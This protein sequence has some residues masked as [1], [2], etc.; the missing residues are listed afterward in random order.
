LHQKSDHG[1][2]SSLGQNAAQFLAEQLRIFGYQVTIGHSDWTLGPNDSPLIE[3][4]IGG[5][6]RRVGAMNDPIDTSE[7]VKLRRKQLQHGVLR[8]VIKHVECLKCQALV[9]AAFQSYPMTVN[10]GLSC[11]SA[12]APSGWKRSYFSMKKRWGIVT[13]K[14]STSMISCY[15]L[16][17]R[18]RNHLDLD[19]I[20]PSGAW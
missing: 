1:F 12:G 2:G 8:L 10:S 13:E 18:F 6:A 11:T 16:M 15:F 19:S 7:W 4:L 3:M 17:K 9:A 20:R 14:L 5:V